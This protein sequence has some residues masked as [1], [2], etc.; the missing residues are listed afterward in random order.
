VMGAPPTASVLEFPPEALAATV[1]V[2]PPVTWDLPAVLAMLAPPELDPPTTPLSD[3]LSV[4][5][6]DE[7]P[8]AV[9]PAN[10]SAI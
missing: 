8:T 6:D 1:P 3:W 4:V 2:F 5:E 7:Q 10:I 9:M